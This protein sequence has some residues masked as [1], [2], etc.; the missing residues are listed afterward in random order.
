MR[1]LEMMSERTLAERGSVCVKADSKLV[2][3]AILVV[4][5]KGEVSR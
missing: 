5:C 4:R 3:R 1:L 2:I